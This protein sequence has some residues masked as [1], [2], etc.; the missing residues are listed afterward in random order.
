MVSFWLHRFFYTTSRYSTLAR[1]TW[2]ITYW[3]NRRNR[4]ATSSP[5]DGRPAQL[6]RVLAQRLRSAWVDDRVEHVQTELPYHAC[7]PYGAPRR[8]SCRSER[9]RTAPIIDST[10]MAGVYS[11][12]WWTVSLADAP[13]RIEGTRRFRLILRGALIKGLTDLAT[14]LPLVRFTGFCVPI[15]GHNVG[16]SRQA[17]PCLSNDY[18]IQI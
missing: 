11:R 1:L 9:H 16:R 15:G 7:I 8:S 5:T 6:V 17:Q 3:R 14:A 2:S 13:P 18:A 10:A 12:S 4:S